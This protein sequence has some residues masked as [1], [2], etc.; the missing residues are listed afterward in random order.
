MSTNRVSSL[1]LVVLVLAGAFLLPA[2]LAAQ[3][4][5]LTRVES[6][7]M[8]AFENE[9]NPDEK[10]QRW[11]FGFG[12][13]YGY[14]FRHFVGTDEQEQRLQEHSQVVNNVNLADLSLRYNFNARTSL[15]LGVPYVQ[16]ER[17]GGLRGPSGDV[18]RRYT[19]S[20]T[21]G[22][23]DVSLVA[24]RLVFD[25]ATHFRSN[26]AI[27][28]GVKF[29]TGDKRQQQRSLSLVNGQEV[30]SFST[31]DLSVQPGDGAW[32]F[33]VDLAG[34]AVLNKSGSLAFYG[35][36]VY[37][38]EPETTNGV[39]RPGA[40]RG[41]EFVSAT[42]QYVMRSGFQFG[43]SAWKGWSV[44]LGGRI[45]GI[46]VHDLFGS[47]YGRRRPG[48]M[49]SVEPTVT[50]AHGVHSVTL[51]MPWAI[52]RNRQRSVSD[53]LRGTHGDAAFPDYLTLATYTRRF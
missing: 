15:T 39:A 3:S 2:S 14:S 46:P 47:S 50:W 52:E 51:A 40:S 32:G 13:R 53:L 8:N 12:W 11:Q 26:L 35:N 20:N 31:A 36:G 37:I 24:K 10:D 44:G 16:A 22:I 30:E 49:L 17:S 27:G 33:V 41:E 28:L 4:C 23:G 18:V 25:P 38:V 45:E 19:R 5:V 7:V 29:P 43:P 21:S 48:Y 9:F 42:D 1:W 34:Y 6:P